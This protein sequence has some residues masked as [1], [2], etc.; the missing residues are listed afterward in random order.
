MSLAINDGYSN[1]M[2]NTTIGVYIYMLVVY[3]N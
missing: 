1:N 3:F 2:Y